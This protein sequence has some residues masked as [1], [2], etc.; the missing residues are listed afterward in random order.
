MVQARSR[1][2]HLFSTLSICI[3][4]VPVLLLTGAAKYLFTPLAMAV[5]FAMMASYLLSRTLVP[6]MVHRMLKPEV[7][8][9]A[10]GEHGEAAG[11]S[12]PIWRIHYL[13]N[14]R[15]ELIRSSYSTLLHWCLDHSVPVLGAFALFGSSP[16]SVI[17][18]EAV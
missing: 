10:T 11:G 17:A 4:F 13:F 3:V 15:F 7:I 18:A 9:Y 16:K 5:V 14:R 8:L 2:R 6:T 12:G 1:R